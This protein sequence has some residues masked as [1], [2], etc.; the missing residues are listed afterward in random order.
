MLPD[1]HGWAADEVCW[2][3]IS[4]ADFTLL[5]PLWI[6]AIFQRFHFWRIAFTIPIT[7]IYV[8][9]KGSSTAHASSISHLIATP[10]SDD[11][12]FVLLALFPPALLWTEVLQEQFPLILCSLLQISCLS[13][14]FHCTYLQWAQRSHCCSAVRPA[15]ATLSLPVF[16]SPRGG[17]VCPPS[18]HPWCLIVFWWPISSH[19]MTCLHFT[20]HW[21]LLHS[22]L[23]A[24]AQHEW[25]KG[26]KNWNDLYR[27]GEGGKKA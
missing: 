4:A 24:I 16:Y 25:V 10:V 22:F 2:G 7:F 9:A 20:P 12:T 27:E 26:K 15:A 14:C 23:F 21:D 17:S 13:L 18:C 5:C 1:R 19:G 6:K 11:G 3:L 8:L